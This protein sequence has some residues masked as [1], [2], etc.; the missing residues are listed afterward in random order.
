MRPAGR[1]GGR[2][3]RHGRY[4]R[5][6]VTGGTHPVRATAAAAAG[7]VGKG[8][9]GKGG[10]KMLSTMDYWSVITE[11]RKWKKN[12][13]E[14]STCDLPCVFVVYP[15][16]K[17]PEGRYAYYGMR[18]WLKTKENHQFKKEGA[19][20]RNNSLHWPCNSKADYSNMQTLAT[21]GVIL[22]GMI[23]YYAC[24]DFV[25]CVFFV[26]SMILHS[27]SCLGNRP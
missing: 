20:L 17:W 14:D 19:S 7:S 5:C 11:H 10:D 13:H 21:Q 22:V 4:H 8:G 23:Y 26:I 15:K 27:C 18:V 6:R 9:R 2:Y 25:I 24:C 1:A 16:L 3:G 12:K